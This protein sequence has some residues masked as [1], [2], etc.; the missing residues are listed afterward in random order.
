MVAHRIRDDY[1]MWPTVAKGLLSPPKV[2]LTK[3][4]KRLNPELSNEIQECDRSFLQSVY[5][6]FCQNL[7]NFIRI[8]KIVF[9]E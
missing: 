3:P 1:I 9:P 5:G 8:N 6:K 2:N 4:E 7:L